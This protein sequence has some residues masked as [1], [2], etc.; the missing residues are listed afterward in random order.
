[1]TVTGISV[2]DGAPRTGSISA[3]VDTGSSLWYMPKA[4]VDTY[5]Q[6]VQ[7][8][9]FGGMQQAWTFP[10]SSKLPD[11]TVHVGSKKIVVPGGNL[12]Y[13]QA[14]PQNCFG[15]LQSDKGM[16]F[17]IFGD[18]FM[19]NLYVIFEHPLQGQPRLGFAKQ[20]R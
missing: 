17:S 15:G 10:C 2:G 19:K 11:I 16:P 1:M 20:A 8:A 4:Y 12:I 14:G 7:G 13:Q 3:V 6:K 5:Y 9:T 18:V